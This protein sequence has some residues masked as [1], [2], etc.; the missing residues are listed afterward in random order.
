MF[1]NQ[2]LQRPL[3]ENIMDKNP[4]GTVIKDDAP[5]YM[6]SLKEKSGLDNN[7]IQIALDEKERKV[8]DDIMKDPP[9]K[10]E[11]DDIQEEITMRAYNQVKDDFD[12]GRING[13]D[14]GA[15]SLD[16]MTNLDAFENPTNDQGLSDFGIT[17][18]ELQNEVDSIMSDINTI[19]N[20]EEFAEPPEDSP[21]LGFD[22]L[23][24]LAEPENKDTEFDFPAPEFDETDEKEP[25]ITM[26]NDSTKE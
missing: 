1:S 10:S 18:P 17:P 16:D 20:S 4:G 22:E 11:Y 26:P 5:L 2:T 25:G 19:N 7:E 21:M 8:N 3:N 24:K 13:E 9:S 14:Q 23:D 15:I 6:Q 12:N